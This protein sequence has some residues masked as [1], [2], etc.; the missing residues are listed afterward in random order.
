[1]Y[2]LTAGVNCWWQQRLKQSIHLWSF[3]N[4]SIFKKR[5]RDN[6]G[7][8]QALKNCRNRMPESLRWVFSLYQPLLLCFLCS[9]FCSRPELPCLHPFMLCWFLKIAKLLGKMVLHLGF[10]LHFNKYQWGW[11]SIYILIDIAEENIFVCFSDQLR[12]FYEIN[13]VHIF[14]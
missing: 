7:I 14:F 10:N 4:F 11:E 5:R 2:S 9:D 6:G 12:F 1:M 3:D 8:I 13:L